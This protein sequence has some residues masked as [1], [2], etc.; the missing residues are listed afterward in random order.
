MPLDAVK[1]SKDIERN[2]G[3]VIE[4]ISTTRLL[5]NRSRIG[6]LYAHHKRDL[7]SIYEGA[8]IKESI[9]GMMSNEF[10]SENEWH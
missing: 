9:L 2:M 8:D 10:R 3:M 5:R 4:G 1:N 6:C 7:Q